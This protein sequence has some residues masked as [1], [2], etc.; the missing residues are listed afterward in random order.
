MRAFDATRPGEGANDVTS[1]GN[2]EHEKETGAETLNAVEN[3]ADAS[4]SYEVSEQQQPQNAENDAEWRKSVATRA[5]VTCLEFRTV[6]GHHG[7]VSQGFDR[8]AT[9]VPPFELYQLRPYRL[10]L[11]QFEDTAKAFANCSPG[12]LQPWVQGQDRPNAESVR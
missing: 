12:L 9:S 8:F 7:T 6:N 11:V 3:L 10:V 2:R 1:A 5:L 4:T